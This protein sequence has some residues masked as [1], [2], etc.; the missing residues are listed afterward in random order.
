MRTN[1]YVE[2]APTGSSRRRRRFS[3]ILASPIFRH[4]YYASP[5]TVV[6]ISKTTSKRVLTPGRTKNLS[7]RRNG[8]KVL[9]KYFTIPRTPFVFLE[10]IR[11]NIVERCDDKKKKDRI[12]WESDKKGIRNY[13]STVRR[14]L[15]TMRFLSSLGHPRNPQRFFQVR[16]IY[17]RRPRSYAL[18]R[19]FVRW[20]RRA[21]DKKK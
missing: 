10:R 14:K 11:G 9:E 5:S 17:P 19:Y 12:E 20:R 4:F 8:V 18:V 13:A 7:N 2:L 6:V 1:D 16:V 21:K 15:W 3:K